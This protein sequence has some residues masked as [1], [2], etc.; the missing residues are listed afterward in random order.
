MYVKQ[1]NYYFFQR[2]LVF[3]FY[4]I[5]FIDF[6]LIDFRRIVHSQCI[7]SQKVHG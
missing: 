1:E 3:F 6:P 5:K 4:F 7:C 2:N